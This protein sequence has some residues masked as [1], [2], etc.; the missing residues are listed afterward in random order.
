MFHNLIVLSNDP[1]TINL[2]SHEIATDLTL[3]SCLP[4]IECY[5][6]S[7]LYNLIVL[8]TEPETMNRLLLLIATQTIS[9]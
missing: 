3:P 1:E 8:S 2:S 9:S 6:V 5:L 4:I 7:L